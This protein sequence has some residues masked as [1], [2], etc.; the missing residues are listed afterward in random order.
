M[1]QFVLD[2][3]VIIQ[4]FNYSEEKHVVEA[5]KIW[6]DLQAGEISIILPSILPLELLNALVKGKN[7]SPEKSYLVLAALFKTQVTIAEI[8][9]PVLGLATKLMEQYNL[10]SY[11]AY[12]LAL[13]QYEGCKLISD[14][15]KAHGKIKDGTVIML[16]QYK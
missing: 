14:D 3:S 9:L 16:G 12:F 1:P 13:A 8:S 2:T 15:K 11:D 5:K 10:T 4:W 6:T 7:C